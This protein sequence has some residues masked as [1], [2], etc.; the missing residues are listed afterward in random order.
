M[1][2]VVPAG[3]V[4]FPRTDLYQCPRDGHILERYRN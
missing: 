4:D 2:L 3:T 1:E